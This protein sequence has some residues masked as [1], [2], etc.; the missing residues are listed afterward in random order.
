[1]LT[2]ARALSLSLLLRAQECLISF[3]SE[4]FPL[5]KAEAYVA[6]VKCAPSKP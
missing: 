6:L 2:R 5:A 3:F 1:V 4:G